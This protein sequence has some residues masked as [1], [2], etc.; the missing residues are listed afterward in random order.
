[1]D[2][3]KVNSVTQIAATGPR[4][5]QKL[6]VLFIAATLLVAALFPRR[7]NKPDAPMPVCEA[8]QECVTY[9]IEP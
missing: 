7:P 4:I 5:S 3:S 2:R 8:G 1:M 6:V 9:E